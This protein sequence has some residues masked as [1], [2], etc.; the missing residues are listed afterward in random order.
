MSTHNLCCIGY[1]TQDKIVTPKSTV[2]MPGGTSF[3]FAHAIKHLSVDDFLLVTAL[4]DSDM[5]VVED[6]KKEGIDVKVLPSTHS[7]CFENIYGNNQNERTQRVT[8]KAD[9]FT[10]EGLQD[11]NAQIIHLGSLLADDFSLDVIKYLSQK[12]LLSVDVQGFLRKVEHNDVLPVDWPEKKEAL[13]HIHILKANE[14]E[15]EV[16]TGCTEPRE[17]A[18]LIADW[19]V[20]EVLLTLGDKGSLIYSNGQF[21]EIPAYPALH[22][23]DATGCGDTYMV[24]YLYMRN[25]GVSYQEAGCYAAAMCTLKLQSHGPFSGSKEAIKK[26]IGSL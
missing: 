2:N 19:G 9:P 17:A 7:V 10:V 23:V 5:G 22:I 4:A 18:L 21:Y 26:V 12:A 14:A 11:I 1:I 25:K 3:Y 8:A 24:G 6:I 20:K 15:M 16:L 13:K